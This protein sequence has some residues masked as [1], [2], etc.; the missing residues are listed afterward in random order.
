VQRHECEANLDRNSATRHRHNRRDFDL[1]DDL[2]LL[3]GEHDVFGGGSVVCLPSMGTRRDISRCG[4]RR[5]LLFLSILPRVSPAALCAQPQG[6]ARGV[7]FEAVE[8][9]GTHL[10]RRRPRVFGRQ[11]RKRRRNL[12]TLPGVIEIDDLR[13]RALR[14]PRPLFFLRVSARGRAWYDDTQ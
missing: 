3:D 14:R 12:T 4:S 6:D 9:R 13:S 11:H 1:G 5:R 10:F 2:R 7:R 8:Q